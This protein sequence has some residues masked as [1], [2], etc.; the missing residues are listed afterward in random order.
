M[1]AHLTICFQVNTL[2]QEKRGLCL[3]NE[4]QYLFADLPDG[5]PNLNTNAYG[6][7]DLAAEEHLIA[8]YPEPGAELIIRHPEKRF[9]LRHARVIR[10]LKLAGAIEME[11][12]L[13]DGDAD[14][15]LN[16][17]QLLMVERVAAARLGGAIWIGNVIERIIAYDN[18]KR[19]NFSPAYLAAPPPTQRA[20]P[21]G[22]NARLPPFRRHVQSSDEEEPEQ[23]VWPQLRFN[24]LFD[25]GDYEQK[26]DTEPQPVRRRKNAR[27]RS[28]LFIDT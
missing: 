23:P 26:E 8:Y 27:R 7:R 15:E 25:E 13:P 22:L 18:I 9:D 20:K 16:G 6:H 19:P 17:D 5:R 2:E 1:T 10:R 14:G 11:E 24:L 21:S 3:Y 12:E 4:K 28:T